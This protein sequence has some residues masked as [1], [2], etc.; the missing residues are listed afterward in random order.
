MRS[1]FGPIFAALLMACG[2]PAMSA[3]AGYEIIAGRVPL[4]WQGP[5]GN[6][7]IIDAP[8][9]LIVVDTGR[10]P[11]HAAMILEHAKS[12]GRPIAAIVNT[13]WHLDH[14]TGN[15]D[16]RA[17]YPA[18]VYGSTAIE[19]ALVG[20]LGNGR[21]QGDK[22]LADP[23]VPEPQKEQMRRGRSR[24]DH[25]DTLRPTVP[26]TRSGPLKIAG[27]RLDVRLARF[28]ASEGDVWFYDRQARVAVVGDLV[29]D[30]VPFMDSACA[31]G[32]KKALAE[33][34]NTGFKTLIPGHGAP[35]DR[36]QF[37][38]W[39][40]AFDNFV[41]CGRSAVAKGKCVDGWMADAAPFIDAAHQDYARAAAEY[42]VDTRLR[43][44]PEEQQKFCKP[45][46][47]S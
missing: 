47:A 34:S 35:M 39:R 40:R 15:A 24:I 18:R 19:G 29:V 27:R 10:S 20:F 21:E 43:S 25:P 46:K 8:G 32:W 9:G 36:A 33:I 7:I 23:K 45:L 42:Y 14:T 44:S 11:M 4:D 13:H 6:T 22:M 37:N 41:D 2:G 1:A 16:I 28:A 12:R 17:V 26:I 38:Q 3:P 31:D 5:D 30:L